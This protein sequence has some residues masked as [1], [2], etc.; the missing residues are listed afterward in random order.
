MICRRTNVA[1]HSRSALAARN[2]RSLSASF[3][4]KVKRSLTFIRFA[5]GLNC[6][7][8]IYIFAFYGSGFYYTIFTILS[9]IYVSNY[10]LIV[11]D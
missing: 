9:G 6:Q 11:M 7:P 10:G 3:T 5:I 2:I 1:G 4:R 8:S